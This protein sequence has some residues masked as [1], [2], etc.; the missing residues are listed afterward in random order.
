MAERLGSGR[1]RLIDLSH[2][3]DAVRAVLEAGYR[4]LSTRAD[5]AALLASEGDSE[6]WPG[7]CPRCGPG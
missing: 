3:G 6:A 5:A 1:G 7:S 2:D 4:G